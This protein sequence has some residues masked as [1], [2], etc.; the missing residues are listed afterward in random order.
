MLTR[1]SFFA[2]SGLGLMAA[3]G[4]PSMFASA[5][6]AQDATAAGQTPSKAPFKLGFAGFTFCKFKLDETLKMIKSVDVHYLCIKDFHLPLNSTPEQIAAFHEKCK[7]F[8]VTGY[9][10]GPIYMNSADEAK[11]AFE[12]AKKCGVKVL[13]GV[14]CEDGTVN[15]KKKRV[16]SRKLLETVDGLVKEYGDIRYAIHN[17]GPDMPELFPTGDSAIEM[18]KDLDKR[19][20][21]CLD[22]GHQF[23]FG[24]DPVKAITDYK[25]RL[26]DLHLKNVSENTRKGG[27]MPLPRGK[28]DLVAVV[29]ALCAVNY[30]GCC[31]LEYE[32]DMAD[33]MLGIAESIGYFR[34]LMDS[35]R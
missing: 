28:I 8:G 19:I 35:V 1:R 29:K 20:G 12:Y 21:L 5:V 16:A 14:P 26:F 13:V 34:G 6:S 15:G 27:A 2:R 31:S 3:A 9:G 22:I 10:V 24:A 32:R 18:I 17:H 23:R 11:R 25:D 30:T 4:M 33:P 7:S